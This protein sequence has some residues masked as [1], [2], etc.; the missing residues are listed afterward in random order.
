MISILHPWLVRRAR[1]SRPTILVLAA[2]LLAAPA[3]AADDPR[4][5]G[6]IV[7]ALRGGLPGNRAPLIHLE[8]RDGKW[9]ETWGEAFDYNTSTHYVKVL[10]SAF[11]GDELK[12]KL[13]VTYRADFWIKPA[14][15]EYTV[16][17]KRGPADNPT[18]SDYARLRSKVAKAALAGNF[19]GTFTGYKGS[20]Q[21]MTGDVVGLLLPWREPPPGFTPAQP[22][23]HP[24]MLF[25]KSELPALRERLKTPL[26]QAVLAELEANGHEVAPAIL[27]QLT[28]NAEYA[29]KSFTRVATGF[30]SEK[31]N[32]LGYG[33][34]E[35]EHVADAPVGHQ[36]AT[37]FVY[38]LC[39]D[40]WT[41][42]Q[43]KATE[44]WLGWMADWAI[45][46]PWSYANT[47]STASPIGHSGITHAGGGIVA[48]ALWGLPSPPP[49]E[50]A[51]SDD[52]LLSAL[53][54]AATPEEL[55]QMRATWREQMELWK[56]GQGMDMK[57]FDLFRLARRGVSCLINEKMGEGGSV[58][59]LSWPRVVLDCSI[60]YRNMF[61][62]DISARDELRTAAV[63]TLRETVA[64][65]TTPAYDQPIGPSGP[66]RI[67]PADVA[68]LLA[69][70]PPEWRPM[71]EDYWLRMVRMKREE[72][73]TVAAW[74][75]FFQRSFAGSEPEP[76]GLL[77]ALHYFGVQPAD[78]RQDVPRVWETIAR[79]E[80]F[81]RGGTVD[82]PILITMDANTS[83]AMGADLSGGNFEIL[84]FGQRWTTS[85]LAGSETRARHNIVYVP[86]QRFNGSAKGKITYR[87]TDPV[88][89][90]GA[91]SLDLSE[92]CREMETRTVS[93]VTTQKV[94]AMLVPK[95]HTDE[96][97]T[98]KDVGLRASRAMA[99]D[100][101]GKCGAPALL[102]IADRFEGPRE[103]CWL[104]NTPDLL[105]PERQS[106]DQGGQPPF[107]VKTDGNTFELRQGE[108][109]VRGVFVAPASIRPAYVD[110]V[111]T[112]L[113]F[114]PTRAKG[115]G[116]LGLRRAGIEARVPATAEPRTDFLV[117]ITVQKGA[118]PEVKGT[119]N[120]ITVG[121]VPVRY[122]GTKIIIG[123]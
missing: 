97:T 111:T 43:R 82:E 71:I 122:D 24:R 54:G 93:T 47:G 59:G 77:Y 65:Q 58:S 27:Y 87:S 80:Y 34:S 39:Y 56:E 26:G 100:F 38:D 63:L 8:C 45:Y 6:E 15:G 88:T 99:V 112:E 92:F 49:P 85:G 115:R 35:S 66:L 14:T 48:W 117:I 57:V 74:R 23:E 67:T 119:G 7:I 19:T 17:V 18:V 79:G 90:N 68:R 61:G 42:G 52:P 110:Q 50:P 94:G 31:G 28:G 109:S 101:S 11:N 95:S 62:A 102:V 113:H 36:A 72:L 29:A 83:G 32:T 86:G 104:L 106:R 120:E 55:E 46:K 4:W 21:T 13:D 107:T 40:A 118:A 9:T 30:T 51:K 33:G 89:G 91:L 78:K 73:T 81:F 3:F 114:H 37:A 25:R 5:A 121:G 69:L 76:W 64:W 84:A 20:P 116:M 60:A 16:T 22:G 123:K 1:R 53:G 70:A 108:A 10:E 75:T 105:P 44:K 12:L 41:V 103:K 98:I 96:V 2:L